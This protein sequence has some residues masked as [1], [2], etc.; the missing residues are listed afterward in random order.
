MKT[1][2]YLL[3][4]LILIFSCGK[5]M[6]NNDSFILDTIDVENLKQYVPNELFESS[7][8]IY[9]DS[10]GEEKIFDIVH[11]VF[12]EDRITDGQSYT[13]NTETINLFD[14]SSNDYRIGMTISGNYYEDQLHK[15]V[16]CSVFTTNQL[17]PQIFIL[18]DGSSFLISSVPEEILNGESFEN[19]FS[20][21]EV[22][23]E[24]Y[25]KI[26]YNFSRGVVGFHGV[27]N[28]LW[29]LKEYQ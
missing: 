27:N 21:I 6:N 16:G 20:S 24:N 7:V 17:I 11:Q 12:N 13:V 5:N 8:A 19:V 10:I 28:K 1:F 15:Q 25:S 29:T 9:V 2:L 3:L 4:S 23:T 22:P 14:R 26:Y 18:E